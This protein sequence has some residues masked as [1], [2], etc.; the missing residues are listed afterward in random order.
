MEY[1]RFD[2]GD[3][4]KYKGEPMYGRVKEYSHLNGYGYIHTGI[5]KEIFVRSYDLG[6]EESNICI[7]AK[8]RF[9]PGVY[10]DKYV[11]KNIEILDRSI[12]NDYVYLPGDNKIQI[13]KITRYGYVSGERTIRTVGIS[14]EELVSHGYTL[15][16]IEYVFVRKTN[17]DEIKIFKFDGPIKGDGQ[18]DDVKALY[19]KL[20]EQFILL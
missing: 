5:G 20:D 8:V 13:E 16:M 4:E 17:G 18:T 3:F 1:R 15:D 2:D 7:G 19:R 12:A 14:E 11:A 9:V 10:E 6:K